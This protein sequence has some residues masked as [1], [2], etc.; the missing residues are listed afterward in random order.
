[1][2]NYTTDIELFLENLDTVITIEELE[3]L[4]KNSNYRSTWQ[5]FSTLITSF[6]PLKQAYLDLANEDKAG[7]VNLAGTSSKELINKSFDGINGLSTNSTVYELASTLYFPGVA[8]V[9]K[10]KEI[11]LIIKKDLETSS[12]FCRIY[13]NINKQVIAEMEVSNLEKDFIYIRNF[14]FLSTKPSIWECHLKV[15]NYNN[16]VKL[17][18]II[19]R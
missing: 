3:L 19:V 4:V 16:K 11:C 15:A 18:G 17:Y 13:D 1:M 9:E 14:N 6:S 2:V 5:D 10:V 12:A 7:K 8:K